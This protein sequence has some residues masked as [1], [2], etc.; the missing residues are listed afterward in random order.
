MLRTHGGSG[1]W[2]VDFETVNVSGTKWKPELR[3]GVS[4]AL[5]WGRMRG[6]VW[7]GLGWGSSLWGL[8]QDA[9]PALTSQEE[10]MVGA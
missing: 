8:G 1:T 5:G 6:V 2:E 10:T 7:E 9:R 4:A 3:K